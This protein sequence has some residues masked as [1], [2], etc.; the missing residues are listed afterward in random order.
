MASVA[1]FLLVGS[2]CRAIAREL[3][4]HRQT[5]SGHRHPR[6]GSKVRSRFPRTVY[7]I[8][9]ENVGNEI[10][11][12]LA[13]QLLENPSLEDYH[14]SVQVMNARFADR[15]FASSMNEGLPLLGRLCEMSGSGTSPFSAA[16][17][18]NSDRYLY[19]I[20]LP[21]PEAKGIKGRPTVTTEELG[22]R[23]GIYLPVHRER[24]IWDPCSPRRWR[25]R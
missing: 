22:I 5:R 7:G 23:Q 13:A 18:R 21:K 10:Y 1:F 3:R 24:S 19:M 25:G 11:G 14:A 6:R 12:G 20:G 2:L 17:R 4:A 8:Y 9:T 15:A 16:G